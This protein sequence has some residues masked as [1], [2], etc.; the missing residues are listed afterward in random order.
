MS[1][2]RTLAPYALI[3]A[4]CLLAYLPAMSGGILWDDDAHI[5]SAALRSLDGLRRI[6]FDL[7]ATQQYYPL[8]HTAFW[9]EH[10]M[11][12]DNTFAYHL[13][14]VLLHAT[15]ACLVVV[16]VRRLLV[17]GEGGAGPRP[18]LRGAEWLAGLL[19]AVHPVAVESVAW[20][21]E[22]KNTLSAVFYLAAALAYLRFD[23]ER[24]PVRYALASAWFVL[25]VLTKTVTVTLPAALLVVFW[26][27]RGRI[28]WRRDVLPLVPWLVLGVSAGLFTAWVERTFIGAQGSEFNLSAVERGLL[29]GRVIWFYLGKLIWPANL[30][31]IYPKWE[32][33]ASVAWQYLF[34]LAAIGLVVLLMRLARRWRGPL[35]AFLIFGGTLFPALG[36]FNVYPFKYS[37]VADHFQYLAS[38]GILVPLA[39]GLTLALR[40]IARRGPA[41]ARGVH[42]GLLAALGVLTWQQCGIYRDS[43]T[44][45]RDIIARNPGCWMPYNNLGMI[46]AADPRRV[47][48]ALDLIQ[49]AIRAN[50]RVAEPYSNLGYL[51]AGM[52]ERMADA[53]R[54]FELALQLDPKLAHAHNNLANVLMKIPGRLD[55]A[56]AHYRLAV[57]FA[58]DAAGMHDNLGTALE[59]TPDGLAEAITH[60]EIACRL[61]PESLDARMHLGR[62]LARLP[63]RFDEAIAHLAAVV[64]RTPDSAEAHE[65]LGTALAQRPDRLP[66]AIRHFETAL[67]LNPDSAS[68]HGNLGAALIKTPGRLRD[69]IAHFEAAVRIDPS[70]IEARQVLGI[71]LSGIP[72]RRQE[73][74]E[75]FE[76]ILRLQPDFAPAREW[77]DRLH[78]APAPR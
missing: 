4:V 49:A 41:V 35:A 42:G 5:T 68:A 72:A 26:W 54:Y 56:I 14:N 43:E 62:A 58:P 22:Q 55:D 16:T 48:E 32:V 17:E 34:P 53:I 27:Q 40:A 38:L 71:L 60:F 78:G 77:R 66:E 39:A 11:W 65:H 8:L 25:A 13:L 36:F 61:D 29:A 30:I 9:L 50:P 20:I 7:G 47:P 33:D 45:Y 15:A 23:R 19:F 28:D 63:G 73:A 57:Q 76:A 70:L 3:F 1:R 75:Q 74:L 52:P 10:H 67:R 44:L 31:F 51:Y 24:R 21:S 18:A 59:Q 64:E 2:L 12:G 69:A 37:Y 6:W 46:A